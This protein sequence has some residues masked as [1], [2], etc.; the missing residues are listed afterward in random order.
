[1]KKIIAGLLALIMNITVPAYAAQGQGLADRWVVRGGAFFVL[2]AQSQVRL[3]QKNG[4][5]GTSIDFD[6]DLEM[7]TSD[8]V[9]RVDGHY[10]FNENHR[11]NL[12]WYEFNRS[13]SKRIQ[14]EIKFGN[15]TFPIDVQVDSFFDMKSFQTSYQWS[16]YNVEKVELG[17][18]IGAHFTD[19]NLGLH[20]PDRAIEESADAFAPL[21]MVGAHL[22]Y[23]ITPN[24]EVLGKWQVF[25]LDIGDYEGIWTDSSLL[26]EHRTFKHVGFGA[27]L[28]AF[29]FDLEATD[30]DFVGSFDLRMSGIFVYMKIF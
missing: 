19:V 27:G 23:S 1:M 11:I 10:R 5:L 25:A 9:A 30:D 16:F 17:V 18:S 15:A 21:P 22:R 26:L 7:D 20:T 2:D 29:T 3:D 6:S 14:K 13:G 28:N 24:L 4:F 12:G 8:T